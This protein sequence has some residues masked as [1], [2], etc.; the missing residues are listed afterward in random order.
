MSK[1]GKPYLKKSFE[2]SGASSDTS[3][4]IYCSMINSAAWLD[5]TA[6][7]KVLYVTCKA[8][9]Y[10]EKKKPIQDDNTTFTMN[11]SKW[12]EKYQLY[13][14]NNQRGFQRDISALISH[15][16]ISCVK[17]GAT[18]RSKSIY[19]FSDKWQ[20]FN[21]SNFEILPNEMNATLIHELKKLEEK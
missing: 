9:Y 16:F 15:G 12:S 5:L 20:H 7:Q 21:E 6:S 11:K 13:T 2:S 8:Q 1:R 19:R 14:A 17:N 4:N 18:T 3:A 10:A